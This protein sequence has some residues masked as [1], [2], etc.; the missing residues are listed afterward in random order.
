MDAAAEQMQSQQQSVIIFPE[1]TRSYYDH[2]DL[3]PFK[4]GAFH[5]AVQ[6]GVPI[7]PIVV[8][9]Y[10]H[11]LNIREMRFNAGTIRVKGGFSR[12]QFLLLYVYA[13]P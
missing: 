5:L 10:S 12:G 13:N 7:V 3:L 11:I 6:A 1:G 9:N 4:K 2:P 8:E